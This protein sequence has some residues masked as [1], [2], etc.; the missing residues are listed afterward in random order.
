MGGWVSNIL[1]VV[2]VICGLGFIDMTSR[3]NPV[4]HQQTRKEERL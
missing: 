3:V 1:T 4:E 2:P